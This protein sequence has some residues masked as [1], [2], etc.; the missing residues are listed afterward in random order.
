MRLLDVQAYQG[1][2]ASVKNS[3]RGY[4][5]LCG[6]YRAAAVTPAKVLLLVCLCAFTAGAQ[7]RAEIRRAEARAE[8]HKVLGGGNPQAA[9]SRLVFLGEQRFA[10]REL[11]RAWDQVLAED[12]RRNV[13]QVV[14]SLAVPAAEPFLVELTSSPDAVLRMH[15]AFGLWRISSRQHAVLEPLLKDPS[16]P[17]RREAARALGQAGLRRSAGPLLAAAKAEGEPEA[18]SAMLLSLGRCGDRKT[19]AALNAFLE[20]SSESARFAAAQG[21]IHL[22]GKKGFEFAGKLLDSEDRFVRR[23][24]VALFEGVGAKQARPHLEPMLDDAD[25]RVAAAAARMLYQGGDTE[26]LSWLVVA[27]WTAAAQDKPH[28]EAELETLMLTDDQRREL[29]RKA[30]LP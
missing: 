4:G 16:W 18:R 6:C 2:G 22:G 27:A 17:V 30:G 12:R 10:A 15:G 25:K 7:G 19:E 26:R 5:R 24:G 14:A 28:Y 20:H 29:L 9:L 23:Q 3:T 11:V 21:L 13:A 8:V 1:K